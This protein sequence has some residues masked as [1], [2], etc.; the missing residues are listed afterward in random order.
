M[1]DSKL[2]YRLPLLLA[3]TMAIGLVLGNLL[4]TGN[5][6][7][8]L[9]GGAA[10][11]RKMQDIIEIL[12]KKYVDSLNGE[13]LFE[14]TISDMLHKLDPHSN[15]IA[16]KDLAEMT[17]SINGE[18]GGVGVRFFILRD[19]VCITNVI[20]FSPSAK[21]GLKAGDKIIEVNGKKIAKKKI[22]SDK[23]MALLKGQEN[24]IVTVKIDR[25]GKQFTKEIVRGAIP[26]E[27]VIS[28]YMIQPKIGYVKI[29]QFSATTTTE[30]EKL[31]NF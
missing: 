12:D 4:S 7:T 19:T 22:N 24:T 30:L 27:S 16:A 17:E 14:Q 13:E 18:F 21:A 11:Y 31:L 26:I 6:D 8:N 28:A 25:N 29:D 10:K 23:V 20:A 5:S 3:L 15:Y 2:N 1:E 9:S